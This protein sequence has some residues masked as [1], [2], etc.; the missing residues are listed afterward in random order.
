METNKETEKLKIEIVDYSERYQHI[1]KSLNVEWIEQFFTM[2]ESDY[3]ALDHPND[4]I[5][6]K[7]GAIL[8]AL[9]SDEPVGVCALIKM[10]DG[11]YDFE[12]AKMAV[13]PKAQGKNIGYL[14]G[15]AIIQK[16]KMLGARKVYLESNT[17]LK[18]A[19][20]LYHKLGFEKVE[21]KYTPYAR[22]NIQMEL[23]VG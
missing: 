3:K 9:L 13:S 5:L 20:N 4:Y 16:A 11:E 21:G 22:C 18:A 6:N 7:G 10:N 14:L 17:V 19:I 12:L 8:V 1:F 23:T 2:E 15:S